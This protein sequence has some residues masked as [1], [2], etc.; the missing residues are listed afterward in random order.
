MHICMYSNRIYIYIYIHTCTCVSVYGT[1][2]IL[3]SKSC[4]FRL[5][6]DGVIMKIEL[7]F[8]YNFNGYFSHR[9]HSR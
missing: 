5:Y 2:R 8:I 7:N 1:Q 4:Q 6:S 9:H 3:I